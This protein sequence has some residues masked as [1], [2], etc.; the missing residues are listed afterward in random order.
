MAMTNYAQNTLTD[1]IFRGQTFAPPTVWYVALWTTAPT[2][3]AGSGVEVVGGNY[4]RIGIASTLTNW[5]GTQGSGTTS[6]STGNSGTTSNNIV[7]TYA[8]PTGNWGTV[9]GI[10]L[11]DA[12]SGGNNWFFNTL[13]TPKSINSG[14][15]APYLPISALQNI[16]N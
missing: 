13:A 10:S 4:S 12:L 15:S 8:A 9:V 11:F 1:F 16:F 7:I 14:D 6:L 5:A 3:V 2:S